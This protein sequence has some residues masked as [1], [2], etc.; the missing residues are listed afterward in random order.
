MEFEIKKEGEKIKVIMEVST[1]KLDIVR[2]DS[3][4]EY[5]EV[6]NIMVY[7][8]ENKKKAL[9]YYENQRKNC[10]NGIEP[11]KKKI[12]EYN[13]EHGEEIFYRISQIKEKLPFNKI[14]G[15]FNNLENYLIKYTEYNS[16]KNQLKLRERDLLVFEDIIK[17]I[18]EC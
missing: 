13:E 16:L 5:G 9:E 10:N 8:F 15:K 6:K 11:I 7:T 14:K 1:D 2:T 3:T 18:E 12:E 4:K 17:K